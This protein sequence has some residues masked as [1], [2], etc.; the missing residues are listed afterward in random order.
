[1][2]MEIMIALLSLLTMLL[3]SL[4]PGWDIRIAQL[5]LNGNCWIGLTIVVVSVILLIAKDNEYL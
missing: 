5:F 3:R 1:M 4:L 2:L